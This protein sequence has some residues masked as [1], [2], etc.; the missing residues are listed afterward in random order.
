M[1]NSPEIPA[2]YIYH[3]SDLPKANAFLHTD[4]G[5]NPKAPMTLNPCRKKNADDRKTSPRS[6]LKLEYGRWRAQLLV[7]QRTLGV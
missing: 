5:G 6:A 2:T 4:S 7:G 1:L 3:I